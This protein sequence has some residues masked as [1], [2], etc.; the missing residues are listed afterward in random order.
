MF[1][2]SIKNMKIM[3]CCSQNHT[4]SNAETPINRRNSKDTHKLE[5]TKKIGKAFMAKINLI[6]MLYFF[7]QI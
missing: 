6:T 7:L 2:K 5:E 3:G 4:S 1:L